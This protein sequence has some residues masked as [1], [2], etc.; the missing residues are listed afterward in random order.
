MA[1]RAPLIW[2]CWLVV[3]IC[4]PFVVIGYAAE[5]AK[6][7]LQRDQERLNRAR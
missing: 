5:V 2:L 7:E 4:I 3:I 1:W 6:E